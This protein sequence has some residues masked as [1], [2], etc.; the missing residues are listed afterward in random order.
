MGAAQLSVS[1]SPITVDA[2]ALWRRSLPREWPQPSAPAHG[3]TGGQRAGA[4][5]RTPCRVLTCH[6]A[7]KLVKVSQHKWPPLESAKHLLRERLTSVCARHKEQRGPFLRVAIQYRHVVPE[8]TWQLPAQL[9]EL[10]LE[11][12]EH[13]LNAFATSL[14]R[15]F[16]VGGNVHTLYRYDAT[17][18]Q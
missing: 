3:R 13:S 1:Q 7:T 5:D 15:C 14:A 9:I 16:A 2:I 10:P 17:A 18:T 11:Y 6:H 8:N 12:F 4:V